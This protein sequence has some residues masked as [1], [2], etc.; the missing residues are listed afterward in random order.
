LSNQAAVLESHSLVIQAQVAWV[1]YLMR[2]FEEAIGHLVQ[3]TR[4]DPTF[5]RPYVNLA[6]CYLQ[7]GEAAKSIEAAETSVTLNHCTVTETILAATLA[8]AGRHVEARQLLDAVVASTQYASAYWL[9][10]ALVFMNDHMAA[11]DSLAKAVDERDWFVL[12]LKVEP[13]FRELH[14]YSRWVDLIDRIHPVTGHT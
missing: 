1:L 9:A 3:L 4:I 13:A 6:W 7:T 10:Y 12:L 14:K 2:R 5:W 8:S 11:L